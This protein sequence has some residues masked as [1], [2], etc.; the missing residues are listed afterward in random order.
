M[1]R[2]E[3]NLSLRR[4]Q[5][6][7]GAELINTYPVA[8][9]KPSTPTPTGSYHITRKIVNPGRFKHPL[10]ELFIPAAE[11]VTEFTAPPSP[12]PSVKPSPKAASACTIMIGTGF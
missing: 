8:I 5:L 9:G 4:L 3:V 10:M 2:I 7:R 6:F 11:A 12:G 1:P